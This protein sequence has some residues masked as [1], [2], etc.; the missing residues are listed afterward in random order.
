MNFKKHLVS[1]IR[2]AKEN[3]QPEVAADLEAE[4]VQVE[5]DLAP[6][7]EKYDLEV[8]TT[9]IL[10]EE[11]KNKFNE[12][13]LS[14]AKATKKNLDAELKRKRWVDSDDEGG[15]DNCFNL[16]PPKPSPKEP[17]VFPPFGPSLKS[18]NDSTPLTAWEQAAA[19]AMMS[20]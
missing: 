6:L 4:L 10:M 11:K 1:Q 19:Q 3:D 13:V 18:N 2:L 15:K 5:K 8:H 7:L 17:F 9:Q 14:A 20:L 12:I 16:K